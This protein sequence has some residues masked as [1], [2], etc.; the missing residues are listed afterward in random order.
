MRFLDEQYR[1][2]PNGSL[3]RSLAELRQLGVDEATLDLLATLIT[4]DTAEET[5]VRAFL[6]TL[7]SVARQ[8][9]ASRQLQRALRNQFKTRDEFDE[10]RRPVNAVVAGAGAP[11][12]AA[13]GQVARF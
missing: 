1:R 9:G 6:E 11:H 8:A 12:V 5:V 13:P 7:E 3:P 4:D 2:T 10:V